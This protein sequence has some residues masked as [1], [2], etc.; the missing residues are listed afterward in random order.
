MARLA[1]AGPPGHAL[2]NDRPPQPVYAGVLPQ[3]ITAAAL[4]ALSANVPATDSDARRP[5]LV[6]LVD[7]GTTQGGLPVV[8][9]HPNPGPYLDELGRA[10]SGRLL[11]LYAMAQR[12]A[13]PDTAPQPAYLVLTDNQGGFPKVGFH[14]QGTAQP[15]VAYV[16]LHRSKSI[17][18]GFAAINQIFPHELVHVIVRDLSGEPRGTGMVQV[19]A[20]GVCTDRATAFTEGFA[21]HVQIVAVDAAGVAPE[22]ARLAGD[23]E[24]RTR[25]ERQLDAY[26]RALAAR[27]AI[28][29]K[30]ALT[31]PFWFS[32]TEQVLRYH[33][34]KANAFAR[35]P[36]IPEAV[37]R[38]NP[39][40]AYL[41]ENI[42][43]GA[44]D[45]AVKSAGRLVATEGVVSTLFYELA[46]SAPLQHRFRD[47]AF[48]RRFGAGRAEIDPVDNIYLKLFAAIREGGYDTVAVLDAYTRLFP[49]DAS[50]VSRIV[51]EVL[52]GQPLPRTPPLW[53]LN[54][55]FLT[56]T[57]LFDQRR[58]MPRPHAFDLNA[59]SMADLARVPG[60]SREA[61]AAILAHA[62]YVSADD[63]GRVPSL[64]DAARMRFAEMARTYTARL[65]APRRRESLSIKGL[66]MPYAWH[67]GAVMLACAAI[68]ALLYRA[69]RR[70]RWWRLALNGAGVSVIGLLVGWTFDNGSGWLALAAPIVLFG[71]P[72]VLIAAWRTRS[73]RAAATVLGAWACASAA[74]MLAVRPIG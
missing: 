35:E 37:S 70:L 24:L 42:L 44:P 10:F 11:R 40:G 20:I 62:P 48:Y 19:H 5:P 41:L 45:G 1:G 28:A 60:V 22:T 32:P 68:G 29:P 12:F 64:D 30:A 43:P 8:E 25:A 59:A 14:F 38:R 57:S 73:L 65:N 66:L 63:L 3:I 2:A 34:V 46:T 71:V 55:A 31:F 26:G 16:D 52:H 18:R 33:A 39:Y 27:W 53:M 74:P 21:E 17:T 54:E 13:H 15:H 67:A 69:V 6:V 4:I 36:P 56:G 47:D 49:E 58:A 72:G 7:T 50:D 51:N 61:A 23:A 9:H